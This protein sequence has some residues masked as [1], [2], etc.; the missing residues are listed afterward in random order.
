MIYLSRY[1]SCQMMRARVISK[2]NEYKKK[3]ISQSIL[4]QTKEKHFIQKQHYQTYLHL[5]TTSKEQRD[6]YRKKIIMHSTFLCH[7]E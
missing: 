4:P 5:P 1:A 7:L 3:N 2:E 6:K